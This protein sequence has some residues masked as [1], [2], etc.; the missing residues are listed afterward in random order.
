MKKLFFAKAFAASLIGLNLW[1]FE[2]ENNKFDNE[3]CLDG[4]GIYPQNCATIKDGAVSILNAERSEKS[5]AEI[6]KVLDTKKL[7]G[8]RVNV[9]VE[10]AQDLTPSVSK[11]GGK[12]F[13]LEGGAKNFYVYAGRY[14]A[15]GKS[16]WEKVEFTTDIPLSS[17]SLRMHLGVES[18]SG[19]VSFRNLKIESTDIL[20]EFANIANL[21]FAKK[22]Y[23]LK[24]FEAF[25]EAGIGYGASEFDT[26]PPP[27]KAA[28]ST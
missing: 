15:P 4:W 13:L 16:D 23:E 24:A 8:R 26:P 25:T 14:V 18:S 11:W 20:A 7:A 1:A 17:N 28:Y 12:I 10:L 3:E 27:P 2:I 5:R 21:G 6:M 9:S 19:K 22:D